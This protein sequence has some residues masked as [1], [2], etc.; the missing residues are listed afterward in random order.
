VLIAGPGKGTEKP[1]ILLRKTLIY[2]TILIGRA[3]AG[4]AMSG[5]R[6]GRSHEP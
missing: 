6:A 5:S 3:T 4:A 2:K 1:A